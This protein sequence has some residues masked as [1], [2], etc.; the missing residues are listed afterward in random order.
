MKSAS[1]SNMPELLCWRLTI[2]ER[3]AQQPPT[4]QLRCLGRERRTRRRRRPRWRRRMRQP[5][6][7]AFEVPHSRSWPTS[8]SGRLRILRTCLSCP[9]CSAPPVCFFLIGGVDN[10]SRIRR[11]HATPLCSRSRSAAKGTSSRGRTWTT[12][13]STASGVLRLI[14]VEPR[15]YC[16]VIRALKPGGVRGAKPPAKKI[17]GVNWIH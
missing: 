11:T 14:A 16:G 3:A 15:D 9:I 13:R 5:Q 2:K 12:P 4:A 7:R 17:G 8:S 1:E 10:L 6:Q